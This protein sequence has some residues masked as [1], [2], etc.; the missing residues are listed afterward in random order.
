MK[1]VKFTGFVKNQ[2]VLNWYKENP[3]TVFVNLSASEGVPV[4]IMEAISMGLP[5]IATDVGGTRE[6][7]ENGKNGYLLDKDCTVSQ[8]VESLNEFH[9]MDNG[10]YKKMCDNALNIW[11][12]RSNAK[13]L[14][15]KFATKLGK[16]SSGSL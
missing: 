14:Y 12:E 15:S 4:A 2:E 13:V 10:S 1:Q 3:A 11:K 16:S 9:I 8:I 6:I 7:V 5:V